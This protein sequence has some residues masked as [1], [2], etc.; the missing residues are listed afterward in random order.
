MPTDEYPSENQAPDRPGMGR[1]VDPS[2]HGW[3]D[4]ATVPY[5]SHG[6][7]ATLVP[8]GYEA[9]VKLLNPFRLTH[10]V[11]LGEALTRPYDEHAEDPDAASGVP[12]VWE[13]LTWRDLLGALH[14]PLT[15]EVDEEVVTEEWPDVWPPNV[16]GPD[17]VTLPALG[18]V[19]AAFTA[20][21]CRLCYDEPTDEPKLVF[22]GTLAEIMNRLGLG[23]GPSIVTCWPADRAWC[24]A[25]PGYAEFTLVGGSEALV[26]TLL[27]CPELEGVRVELTTGLSRRGE[28]R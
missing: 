7:V 14:L 2:A 6:T 3:I 19:L 8:G 20:G 1:R 24:V 9:Y 21:A 28:H 15:P 4:A 13:R 18:R 27:E 5:R 11:L 22:E 23:T 12:R 25:V 26:R 16:G 10:G 17:E